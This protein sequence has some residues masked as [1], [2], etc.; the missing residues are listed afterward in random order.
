MLERVHKA[1]PDAAIEGFVV[2]PMATRP[3]SQELLVGIAQ[4]SGLRSGRAVSARAVSR[5]RCWPTAVSACRR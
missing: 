5:P 4:G 1:R 3:H 2:E